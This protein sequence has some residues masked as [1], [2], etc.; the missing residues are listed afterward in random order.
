MLKLKLQHYI[1]HIALVLDTSSSMAG[2]MR[3]VEK[4]F[5]L[6]IEHL[7]NRSKELNQETRVSVYEFNNLVQCLVFDMDVMRMPSLQGQMQASGMTALLD[8]GARAIKD[9]ETLPQKYGDH[10]FL[11]YILTDGEENQSRNINAKGFSSLL[12]G[13]PDNWTVAAM[14]PNTIGMHEAKK[15]GFPANNVQMWST[16]AA[17]IQE[18]GKVT[19][20]AVDSYMDMRSRGIR[21][22]KSLYSVDLSSVDTK[23]V[24]KTLTELDPSTY[25]I[26]R[27]GSKQEVIKPFIERWTKKTYRIGSAYYELVKPE[28]IQ[29]SKSICIQH[30][31]NGR[32][33]SGSEARNL[34]GLPATS[35]R[36]KPGDHGDWHI[37]VQST[38]WNRNLP[39]NTSVLFMQ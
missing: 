6:Q 5:D 11:L 8:A 13:L 34:L 31:Q 10:A 38:S 37:F 29:A 24:I 4:V 18:V 39:P 20:V 15:F 32:V 1:N 19:K 7:R 23:T 16:D 22:T 9:M 3:D 27:V 21:S 36:V 28:D 25:N 26:F 33:Y 35:L 12:E 17:G 2:R 14:V 30:K